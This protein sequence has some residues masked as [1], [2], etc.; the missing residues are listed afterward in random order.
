MTPAWFA[1][2]YLATIVPA[3]HVMATG[4]LRGIRSRVETARDDRSRRPRR[5]GAADDGVRVEHELV[6]LHA[7]GVPALGHA[8]TTISRSGGEACGRPMWAPSNHA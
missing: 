6:D 2:L 4:M 1:A 8:P 5:G 7:G 3:D